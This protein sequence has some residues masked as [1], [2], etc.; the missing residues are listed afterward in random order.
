MGTLADS[1]QRLRAIAAEGDTVTVHDPASASEIEAAERRL[2]IAFPEEL[3]EVY[4]H[5]NGFELAPNFS[6]VPVDKVNHFAAAIDEEPV[7]FYYDDLTGENEDDHLVRMDRVQAFDVSNGS[8]LSCVTLPDGR[9]RWLD[10]FREETQQFLDWN[11]AALIDRACES[12]SGKS[13]HTF[14]L[15]E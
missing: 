13:V 11:A 9:V 5:C 10:D 14:W 7:G 1:V 15:E 2:G 6:L 3:R 12:F 4:R 8:Y